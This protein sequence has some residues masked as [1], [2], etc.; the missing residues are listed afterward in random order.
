MVIIVCSF[1]MC[2]SVR[3]VQVHSFG[4]CVCEHLKYAA[5][6]CVCA[7]HPTYTAFACVCICASQKRRLC[8]CVYASL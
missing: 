4:M 3:A 5:F 1:G 6:M 7:V 2:V 8:E